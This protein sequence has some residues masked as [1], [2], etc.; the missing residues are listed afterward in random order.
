MADTNV[1]VNLINE[2]I[3]G[4]IKLA[5]YISSLFRHPKVDNSHIGVTSETDF[6][7]GA[8]WASSLDFIAVKILQKYGRH[9]TDEEIMLSLKTIYQ[10][11]PEF[12]EAISKLGL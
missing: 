3:N 1:I 11:A 7:L 6:Y 10:R 4:A 2:Q 9:P 12:R 5:P 8:M